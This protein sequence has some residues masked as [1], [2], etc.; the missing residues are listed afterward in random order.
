VLKFQVDSA[1]FH[2][3]QAC[4]NFGGNVEQEEN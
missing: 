2:G 4:G 3:G 1:Y